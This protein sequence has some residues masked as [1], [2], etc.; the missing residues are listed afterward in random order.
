VEG[1]SMQPETHRNST[2]KKKLLEH[3]NENEEV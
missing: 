1:N 3:I 2:R